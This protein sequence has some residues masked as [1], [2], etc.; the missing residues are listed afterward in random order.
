MN[1][2]ASARAGPAPP[3]TAYGASGTV[4]NNGICCITIIVRLRL[5]GCADEGCWEG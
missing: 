5:L 2:T 3:F 1:A 4:F